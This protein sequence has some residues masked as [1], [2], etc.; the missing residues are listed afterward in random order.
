M[1]DNNTNI[2]K[3]KYNLQLTKVE[4]GK[5][6]FRCMKNENHGLYTRNITKDHSN[7]KNPYTPL[8]GCPECVIKLKPWINSNNG[9]YYVAFNMKGK[10]Y[11]QQKKVCFNCYTKRGKVTGS[12]VLINDNVLC[13]ACAKKHKSSNV[14]MNLFTEWSKVN[15]NIKPD[16]S[17]FPLGYDINTMLKFKCMTNVKHGVKESL[18]SLGYIGKQVPRIISGCWECIIKNGSIKKHPVTD[19]F[20]LLQI[21]NGKRIYRNICQNY[22]DLSKSHIVTLSNN[23][24]FCSKCKISSD[25]EI[26]IKVVKGS[27]SK[28]SLFKKEQNIYTTMNDWLKDKYNLDVIGTHKNDHPKNKQLYYKCKCPVESHNEIFITE[29]MSGFKHRSITKHFGCL[30]CREMNGT[31]DYKNNGRWCRAHIRKSKGMSLYEEKYMCINYTLE[32][33]DQHDIPR[34]KSGPGI[35]NKCKNIKKGPTSVLI[36]IATNQQT[37]DNDENTEFRQYIHEKY[38][39]NV[40]EKKLNFDKPEKCKITV[41]CLVNENHPVFRPA[42]GLR[43][44]SYKTKADSHH[45]VCCPICLPDKSIMKYKILGSGDKYKYVKIKTKN[46]RRVATNICQNYENDNSH[47]SGK[48]VSKSHMIN[49]YMYCIGCYKKQS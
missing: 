25:D 33:K 46:K 44:F 22:N 10:P 47:I 5:G 28:Q 38:N 13:L 49:G 40:L 39:V 17:E 29:R 23:I 4:N 1:T 7:F 9:H 48:E 18:N 14:N 31:V 30:E 8:F 3:E 37:N 36:K 24:E 42:S 26:K 16:F 6:V 19:K 43:A 45:L 21:V 41:K 35:C 15:F 12:K 20:K 34:K 27:A 2:F 32:T 11:L